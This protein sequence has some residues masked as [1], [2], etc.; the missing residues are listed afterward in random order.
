MKIIFLLV[1]ITFSFTASAVSYP[2]DD[3]P[4]S[5]AQT[6]GSNKPNV[7]LSTSNAI[8]NAL[9]GNKLGYRNQD[10]TNSSSSTCGSSNCVGVSNLRGDT[11]DWS[12]PSGAQTVTIQG[13]K[14]LDT[15]VY[16][17]TS[18]EVKLDGSTLTINGDVTLYVDKMT[19]VSSGNIVANNSATLVVVAVNSGETVS[20]KGSSSFKGHFF[21]RGFLEL[22]EN[23]TLTGTVTTDDLKIYDNAQLIGEL[24]PEPPIQ[25][26]E[27][28]GNKD[29]IATMT[30]SG[31]NTYQ[32]FYFT[33]SS[34][35]QRY[36]T[37]WYTQ[38]IN[39]DSDYIFNEQSLVPGGEYELRFDHDADSDKSYYYRRNSG[40]TNWEYITSDSTPIQNGNIVGEGDGVTSYEC[41]EED[42]TPPIEYSNDAQ[43]VLGVEQCDSFPCTIKFRKFD[44]TPLVF[45]MPTVSE[46]NPDQD[47]PSRLYITSELTENST[48]VVIDQ[49]S[50]PDLRSSY[51]H[52]PMKDIS[53]LI[54]EPGIATID[55]HKVVAGY[56]NTDQYAARGGPRDYATV[57]F[58][59]F[60]LESNFSADPV[61]L[62][63]LQTNSN[64]G[65]WT[66]S[67]RRDDGGEMDSEIRL[68]I[69]LSDSEDDDHTYVSEKIAFLATEPSSVL[70]AASYEIQFDHFAMVRQSGTNS[71]LLDGCERS[72]ASTSLSEVSG[73]I[74]KKQQ[75][76][77]GDG[78]W[79]RRCA[80][81]DTTAT[82]VMDEDRSARSHIPERGGYIAFE[83]ISLDVCEYFPT[84]LQT[85]SYY[86]ADPN[87]NGSPFASQIS[88]S[89][90][91]SKIFLESR[92][93]LSFNAITT[94]GTETG[95]VYDGSSVESCNV[96]PSLTYDD[97]PPVLPSFKT[98]GTTETC[99]NGCNDSI[100]SGVYSTVTIG[101]NQSTLTFNEG[102]YW[103]ENLVLSGHDAKLNT[104]GTVTIHYQSL[105]I[106]G[107]RVQLNSNGNFGQ[108]F[109]IGH[110]QGSNVTVSNNDVQ[111]KGNLY[112]DAVNGA[113][114]GLTV[115]GARFTHEGGISAQQILV[116]NHDATFTTRAPADC[117]ISE[118]EYQLDLTPEKDFSLLC[119]NP[120]VTV[121]VV[122]AS[123]DEVNQAIEVYVTLPSGITVSSVINGSDNGGESY[124]T[125][126]SG[127]LT[128]ALDSAAIGTY[129][130]SAELASDST[131]FDSGELLVSL[132]KFEAS[133]VYAIAGKSAEFT[134][135]VLACKNDSVTPVS[136][137]SGKKSLT[138][139]DFTFITPSSSQN[140]TD[141]GLQISG[142]GGT[143][144]SNSSAIFDFSNAV[145]A[146]NGLIN[147]SES[148]SISFKLSDPTF[149]CPIG[150]DCE[151]NEGGDWNTLEGV[152]NVSVRPWTFAVC[153]PSG[154]TTGGDASTG[155]GF[156]A[157]GE[158]FSLYVKP[159][160][161][162]STLDIVDSDSGEALRLHQKKEPSAN[163]FCSLDVTNNFF[164]N[165]STLN[166]IVGVANSLAT[167]SGGELG[168][169]YLESVNSYASTSELEFS[170][171]SVREV[172]SFHFTA[173]TSNAFYNGILNGID[174]GARELGRFYP[175]YFQTVG[176]PIWD[177]PDVVSVVSGNPVEQSFSYMNQPFDGVEFEVEALNALGNAIENYASFDSTLTAGFSL[178]EPNF[179]DRFNSPVPNKVW[180]ATNNRSIGTFTLSQS[181]P[182]T[183]CDS[184]LCLEKLPTAD[185]Y[186][187][188]PYNGATGTVT[189]I[190]ITH[191]G[192]AD[193]DPV[194]YLN[195]EGSRDPQRLT[196]QPEILFGRVDLDDVGGNSETT[197]TIPLR[198]EYWN[199]SRFVVNDADST[200]NIAASTSASNVIWSEDDSSA[201]TATLSDGGQ[202]SGGES[203]NLTASQG[204]GVSI[205]E[206]VQ[207]W[208]NMDDIPWLR[209]DWDSDKV[210]D[211]VNGEQDPSTVVTF[212]I[213]RGNDRVIYRGESGLTGQ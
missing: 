164:I 127:I 130:I 62:H 121:T 54:M 211:E 206:Q 129:T 208:Q 34:G 105:S 58:E 45:V 183:D 65:F 160:V 172:G 26:C 199:G 74:G 169:A 207:L 97:F 122:D 14:T 210:S 113:S 140:P 67:G 37:L 51:E 68:F 2:V 12:I 66:T 84:A 15:G 98:G 24:P 36:Q 190:S 198:T 185:N 181:S 123:G 41:E 76:S 115:S 165:N 31:S 33:N 91:R 48:S 6:W 80:I 47:A 96:N 213:Y 19:V 18:S 135:E 116:T 176:T 170:N 202:V 20:L 136:G 27:V 43:Y 9:D 23:V 7:D 40:D 139:S 78:G 53:F 155:D 195:E 191:T 73:I 179:G 114:Q 142:D 188:G 167:P 8:L 189:D 11:P 205:R 161:W 29:F 44:F 39:S 147:Y 159:V 5:A 168:D 99:R 156:V 204:D 77:G 119:E 128:L 60:G 3:L 157:A 174:D 89:G 180:T 69:E 106:G 171:V 186:E 133:E 93:D 46:V 25:S 187:D 57:E 21:T 118:V 63:Q 163:P 166:T 81:N 196:E 85:N 131:Q 52:V 16:D 184:E 203:R 102:I 103:I 110:G 138:V 35:N 173:S 124:L 83:E 70:D 71:S 148:G 149:E 197:I 55:G 88:L 126:T 143:T 193:D 111:I 120:E 144:W 108:L 107:D 50:L 30:V 82:F 209:Y 42:V 134:L 177:Y 182:S 145:A 158:T 90:D 151:D 109:L 137:Y 194:A 49:Q 56:A 162:S 86:S 72:I 28:Q 125:D 212:G 92:K 59:D 13:N 192:S 79:L 94:S 61:V 200:T 75:R 17:A 22:A 1:S 10:I 175:K 152:V 201:T 104:N 38:T 95:C 32:E 4:E 146:P 153:P 117:E 150:Y 154:A 87:D 141:G 64:D 101:N 112:I 132:Y 100:N 178:F